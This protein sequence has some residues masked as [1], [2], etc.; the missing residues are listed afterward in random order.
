M[1][2]PDP[3][4][5]SI[6]NRV[7]KT[8]DRRYTH[9]YRRKRRRETNWT[10]I[11]WYSVG[12]CWGWIRRGHSFRPV[13]IEGVSWVLLGKALAETGMIDMTD[14]GIIMGNVINDT[15][16]NTPPV[17]THEGR[18]MASMK[19]GPYRVTGTKSISTKNGISIKRGTTN[20]SRKRVHQAPNQTKAK[21]LQEDLNCVP[22][23]RQN[24]ATPGRL[25]TTIAEKRDITVTNV[26]LKAT[27]N[28]RQ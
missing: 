26:W 7:T 6:G 24:P 19:T 28:D 12:W 3:M 27:I 23:Q 20:E 15:T 11:V 9:V 2:K 1:M 22:E 8:I 14:N 13:G 10:F 21:D 16:G 17:I 25:T 5:R 18:T 4:I